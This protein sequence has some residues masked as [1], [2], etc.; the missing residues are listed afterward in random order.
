M[1]INTEQGV[2]A[3]GGSGITAAGTSERASVHT[4][5]RKS[6]ARQQVLH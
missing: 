2:C 5:R 3:E 1:Q 6:E 4:C